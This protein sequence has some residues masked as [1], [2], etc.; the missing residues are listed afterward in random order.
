M[1]EKG[2]FYAGAA[3]GLAIALLLVVLVAVYPQANPTI[4]GS[5]ATTTALN[6]STECSAC[7]AAC[8]IIIPQTTSA[9]GAQA[10]VNTPG[11]GATSTP[12]VET[13]PNATTPSQAQRPDSLLAVLPGEG[14]GSLLATISP[15]L[16][17]LLVAG[18]VYGAYS[19]RQDASS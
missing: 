18:L 6:A 5:S 9:S 12:I 13:A 16:I 1:M 14:V 8:E 17:A 2:G 19:R 11:A 3:G 7:C 15:L 10:Q 4:S